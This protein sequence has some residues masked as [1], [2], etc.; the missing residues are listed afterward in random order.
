MHKQEK[1]FVNELGNSIKVKVSEIDIKGIKGVSILIAGPTSETENQITL[2][3]AKI[4]HE[5]LGILLENL[6]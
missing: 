3:E 1:Q 4:I 2:I 5:Q 6:E